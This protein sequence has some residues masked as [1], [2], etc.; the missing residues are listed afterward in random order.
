MGR[1]RCR[2]FSLVK[3]HQWKKPSRQVFNIIIFFLR[4]RE[5]NQKRHVRDKVSLRVTRG[6]QIVIK[7][8]AIYR[9]P[10]LYL[11]SIRIYKTDTD[12]LR[13]RSINKN[14]IE[15]SSA[16]IGWDID[17]IGRKTPQITLTIVELLILVLFPVVNYL[18][19]FSTH[20]IIVKTKIM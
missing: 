8:H 5:V 15:R 6:R 17:S 3:N 9:L 20:R 14:A 18:A 10:L 2:F 7:R 16:F 19:T 1:R 13:I 11:A 4:W 12:K